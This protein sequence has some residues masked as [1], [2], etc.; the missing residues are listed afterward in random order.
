MKSLNPMA[1]GC[2]VFE[3]VYNIGPG[4]E[5]GVKRDNISGGKKK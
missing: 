1:L 4:D 2:N 3:L 5:F